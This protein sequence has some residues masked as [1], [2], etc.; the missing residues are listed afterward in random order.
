MEL[1]D[2]AQM[3]ISC[4][5]LAMGTSRTE[6]TDLWLADA[7]VKARAKESGFDEET[8]RDRIQIQ[9]ARADG[10]SNQLQKR[11]RPVWDAAR[12]LHLEH[13]RDRHAQL[14]KRADALADKV[15]DEWER[16]GEIL[17]SQGMAFL[18]GEFLAEEDEGDTTKAQSAGEAAS[19]LAASRAA[20]KDAL[21]LLAH[22]IQQDEKQLALPLEDAEV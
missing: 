8:A 11:L 18:E 5:R 10:N 15:T 3:S 21:N 6:L 4:E 22:R 14:V 19:M 20:T 2:K 12:A 17:Q 9:L 16:Q 1:L 7:D 13:V